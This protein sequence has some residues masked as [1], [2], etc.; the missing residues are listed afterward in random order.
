MLPPPVLVDGDYADRPA[1]R[2][3]DW[4]GIIRGI[5]ARLGAA[6]DSDGDDAG[7]G[8][9]QARHPGHEIDRPQSPEPITTDPLGLGED[10]G[11]LAADQRA[12]DQARALGTARAVYAIDAGADGSDGHRPGDLQ[13][14]L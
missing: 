5:D 6:A 14:D 4:A 8:L 2:P 3:D 10:D 12:M 7:G 1:A 11:D 9:E 13:L